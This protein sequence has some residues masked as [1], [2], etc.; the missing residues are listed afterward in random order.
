MILLLSLLSVFG[1]SGPTDLFSKTY[2]DGFSE[3]NRILFNNADLEVHYEFDAV[4]I[5]QSTGGDPII[6]TLSYTLIVTNNGPEDATN[7]KVAINY[8]DEVIPF[9]RVMSSGYWENYQWVIPDLPA[10]S[11]VELI[12]FSNIFIPYNNKWVQAS[13]QE[14]DQYDPD[15]TP[16]NWDF[17]EDDSDMLEIYSPQSDLDL[18]LAVDNFEYDIYE[19]INYEVV[20][21]NFG[22][23]VATN[24]TVYFPLPSGMVFS[25]SA[26]TQGNYNLYYE[27]WNIGTLAI[28]QTVLLNLELFTLNASGPKT[29]FAQVQTLDQPDPDSTPGNDT[30]QTPDEDDE[31]E[32]TIYPDGYGLPDYCESSSDFP[33]HEWISRIRLNTLD[34]SSGKSYY[35][36]FT[37]MSTNLQKGGTYTITLQTSFSYTTYDEYWRVWIDFNQNGSFTDSG[38]MVVN[39]VLNRPPNGTPIAS[40]NENIDIPLNSL[41]GNTRMRVSMQRG[42]APTPCAILPF[43]EVEDYTININE[44]LPPVLE[45]QCPENI[46]LSIASDLGGA[47]VTWDLP[48]FNSS[49]STGSVS[50]TQ[51]GG[52]PNGS[53]FDTGVYF[54][55]YTATDDCGNEESCS[56]ELYVEENSDYCESESDFPWHEWIG[57]V[58]FADIENTSGKSKYSDFTSITTVVE[59]GINYPITLQT[60]FSY[61]T[62]DEYWRIW[63]DFNQNGSFADPGE[64][65]FD[66]ILSKPPN[67]TPFATIAGSIFIPENTLEGNTRMRI[68][69]QRG[70]PPSPCGVIPFGEVEDYTLSISNSFGGSANVRMRS[71]DIQVVLFPNPVV[72]EVY[73]NLIEHVDQSATISIYDLYGHKILDNQIEEIPNYPIRIDLS[74]V[75]NGIYFLSIKVDQLKITTKKLVVEKVK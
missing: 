43:G 74:G 3:N 75:K 46:F 56:F 73:V 11:T 52:Q 69:M 22:P 44:N 66:Q 12:E 33:W 57:K 59:N 9:D 47:N 36:D 28:G 53:F 42:N 5:T 54:I 25:G 29:A 21:Q 2:T 61:T 14:M 1:A 71:N 31:A 6:G 16:G 23:S 58:T 39:N 41:P 37:S 64:M 13:L 8:H 10:G 17:A 35:S 55:A 40:L 38:E 7:V 51:T 68:S 34:Q 19:H 63:I 24:V 4:Q 15:S 48:T 32:V 20:V 67:G 72:N 45:L 18:T 27:T 60:N 49:C 30:D 50:L 70:N 65:V 62:Y 26:A